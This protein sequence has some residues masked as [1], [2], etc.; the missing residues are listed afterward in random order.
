MMVKVVLH[1]QRGAGEVTLDARTAADAIEGFARQTGVFDND[2]LANRPLLRV[3]GF[4]TEESLRE[5]LRPE[6]TELH[7]LPAMV[8]GGGNFGRIII[9]GALIVAGLVVAPYSPMLGS[10]LVGA[11]IGMA[12]GGVMGFFMKSPKASKS[13]D[14]EASKYFGTRQNTTAS[15][16]PIARRYGRNAVFGQILAVNVDAQD[17]ILGQFPA[18]V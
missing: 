15:G 2:L 1:G 13:T 5:P 17:M 16:T 8:G 4:P 9:G 12:V 14:P 18:S 10:A 6:I 3:V 7:L 11:G